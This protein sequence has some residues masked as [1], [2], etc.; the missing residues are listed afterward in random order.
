MA[1]LKIESIDSLR[2]RVRAVRAAGKSIGC[3]PTMGALHAGHAALLNRAREDCSFLVATLF[4]NPMQFNKRSDLERYPRSLEDDLAICRRHG[5]DVLFVPSEAEMY[6]RR[7]ATFVDVKSLTDVL[8][9]AF[10]PGHFRGVTTVV[11]KLLHIVVPDRA[12]FG[13]KDYQQ[14]AVIRRMVE[15]LNMPVEIVSVETVRDSDGLALSSRNKLLT[16][17]QRTA[18]LALPRALQAARR[19]V[20]AGERDPET[21]RRAARRRFDRELLLRLEYFEIVD[22]DSLQRVE[23]IAGPVRIAAA[24]WAGETRLIDNTAAGRPLAFRR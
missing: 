5:V 21:L 3:V 24:A 10:R 11:M 2:T 12:Y 4:V 14:L 23:R 20:A 8:C 15:D 19:A 13:E 16:A 6:P 9:G 17:E 18:A 7:A 1:T 22:P